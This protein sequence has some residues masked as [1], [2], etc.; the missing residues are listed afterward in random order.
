MRGEEKTFIQRNRYFST[1]LNSNIFQI[2]GDSRHRNNPYLKP[3][4]KENVEA[5]QVYKT[6][7]TKTAKTLF[8]LKQIVA[9]FTAV[10]VFLDPCV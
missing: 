3:K 10:Q 6:L 5:K 8:T 4:K 1:L 7:A 2:F 9:Q